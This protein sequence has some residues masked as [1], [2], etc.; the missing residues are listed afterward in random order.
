MRHGPSMP[1]SLH[2]K[3]S[4]RLWLWAFALVLAWGLVAVSPHTALAAIDCDSVDEIPVAECQALVALYHSTGGA[5]WGV[6]DNWL[7]T[8]TPCSWYG[9]TCASGSAPE[10]VTGLDLSGNGLRGDIPAE[11]DGLTSLQVLDLANNH[12]TGLPPTIGS[13]TSLQYLDLY[14]N[15][16]TSLPPEIGNLTQLEALSLNYNHLGGLPDT[17]GGLTRLQGLYLAYNYLRE[18]PSSIGNLTELREL[19]LYDNQLASLPDSIGS[20]RSLERLNLY[21]NHLTSLPDSIGNL[22]NLNLLSLS[23]NQ[24]TSLPDSIGNLHSLERL[25]VYDNQ[26]TGLPATFGNLTELRRLNLHENQLT[27]VFGEIGNLTNLE[28]LDLHANPD[29]AGPLP[30]SLIQFTELVSFYYADT[31]LCEPEDVAIQAWLGSIPDLSRT[32][33]LCSTGGPGTVTIVKD[34][35]PNSRRN[36]RFA[37]DLGEFRLDNVLPDDADGYDKSQTFTLAPGVYQVAEQVP[38]TWMLAG[39][40]CDPSAS[41]VLDPAS[42]QVSITLSGDDHVTCT[43]TNH[44]LSLLRAQLYQDDNGDAQRNEGE[45]AIP[46]WRVSLYDAQQTLVATQRANEFGKVSFPGLPPGNY[47]VCEEL[48]RGWYN[49]LP[50]LIDA[51][52]GEPCYLLTLGVGQ[53]ALAMFGNVDRPVAQAAGVAAGAGI[54]IADRPDDEPDDDRYTAADSDEAWLTQA[55]DIDQTSGVGLYLPLITV[56]RQ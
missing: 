46:G 16:M 9:V 54:V 34:A 2:R 6:Q 55:D 28:F 38:G 14:D 40:A 43:F 47:T 33:I 20:L 32:N 24:L 29:L 3:P 5:D 11:I 50:G 49:T 18:L 51:V 30:A 19:A 26:L 31:Q 27:S 48:E 52:L 35:Q 7:V 39:I 36:F 21:E 8:T 1:S 56:E 13:L 41:A 25:A 17:I 23:E 10:H 22:S 44:R 37:G 42:H 45:A 15:D 53:V 12:V 4:T